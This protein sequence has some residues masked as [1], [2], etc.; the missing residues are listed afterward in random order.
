MNKLPAKLKQPQL[1]AD[2]KEWKENGLKL[3]SKHVEQALLKKVVD[4]FQ[5]TAQ[6]MAQEKVDITKFEEVISQLSES[7]KRID[8]KH[9]GK[10]ANNF[11]GKNL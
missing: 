5:K 10:G 1:E 2:L 4:E 8:E 11:Q 9:T 6:V 7:V 3:M